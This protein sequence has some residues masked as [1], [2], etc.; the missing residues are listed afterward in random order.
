MK[1]HII[2]RCTR[3]ENL[4]QVRDSIFNNKPRSVEITWNVVFDTAKMDSISSELLHELSDRGVRFH[5]PKCG[6]WECQ[7]QFSNELMTYYIRDGFIVHHNHFVVYFVKC[8]F[9][10]I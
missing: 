4:I 10:I 9:Q 6:S 5:F 1:I 3:S 7:Y 2:T 8:L